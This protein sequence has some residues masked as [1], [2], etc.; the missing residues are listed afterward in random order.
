MA[1]RSEIGAFS[2]LPGMRTFLPEAS[3][4]DLAA[5]DRALSFLSEAGFQRVDTPILEDSDLFARKGGGG[6]TGLLYTFSEPDGRRLSLRPE[7]HDL[8]HPHVRGK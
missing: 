5:S 8:H 7:F 3:R 6:M 1:G 4:S 2:G